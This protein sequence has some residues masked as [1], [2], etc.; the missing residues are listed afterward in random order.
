MDS[1]K[2]KNKLRISTKKNQR[3]VFRKLIQFKQRIFAIQDT[4]RDDTDA[5]EPDVKIAV[6]SSSWFSREIQFDYKYFFLKTKSYAAIIKTDGTIVERN[7]IFKGQF[8][9]KTTSGNFFNDYF[10]KKKSEMFIT[11]FKTLVSG[12]NVTFTVQTSKKSK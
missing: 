10:S 5:P 8:T 11:C 2:N 12:Y 9:N 6:K 1:I 4:Q 7:Q 3:H